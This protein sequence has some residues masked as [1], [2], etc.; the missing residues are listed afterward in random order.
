MG[1]LLAHAEQVGDSY[2]ACGLDHGRT[3]RT[4]PDQCISVKDVIRVV[5]L[6]MVTFVFAAC[7][8]PAREE[9]TPLVGEWVGIHDCQAIVDALRAAGFDE[10]VVLETVVGNGLVP[11]ANTPEDLA[12]PAD[13]CRDAVLREHSHFFTAE[14]AF[15]SRDFDGRQV[16]EGTYEILDKDTLSISGRGDENR[17]VTAEFGF[18]IDADTLTLEALVPDGCLTPDCQWAI[19]VAMAGQPM[20]R[21]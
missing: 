11:D 17:P 5:L 12:D 1:A 19:M 4:P 13:P 9:P 3:G 21:T 16:D 2:N 15:G 18:K 6:I 8:E 20:K 7:A 14:G 10:S